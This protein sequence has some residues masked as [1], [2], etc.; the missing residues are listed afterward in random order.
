PRRQPRR[1][2]GGNRLGYAGGRKRLEIPIFKGDDAYGWFVRVECYFRLNEVCMQDKVDMVVLAME[3]KA[4]NWFQWWE[5]QT[6][7]RNWEE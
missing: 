6:P 4:L 2:D 3:E 1:H 7:L 5:E